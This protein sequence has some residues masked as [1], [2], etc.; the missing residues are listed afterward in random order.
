MSSSI[1]PQYLTLPV[2]TER[3]DDVP[4]DGREDAVLLPTGDVQAE[5]SGESP[6]G[7]VEQQGS[8]SSEEVPGTAVATSS[9]VDPVDREFLQAVV[10]AELDALAPEIAEHLAEVLFRRMRAA[11]NP[12][13]SE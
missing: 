12:E 1:P 11:R 10:R 3:I 2:L 6:D 5:P 9:A 7:A 13:E 4:D 8:V